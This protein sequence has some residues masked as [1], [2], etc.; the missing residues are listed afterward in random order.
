M[1]DKT[2]RA[3]GKLD[4]AEGTPDIFPEAGRDG[5]FAK[6]RYLFEGVMVL[7][8]IRLRSTLIYQKGR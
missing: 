8:I 4:V 6:E 2:L 3:V 1:G 5:L 7:E